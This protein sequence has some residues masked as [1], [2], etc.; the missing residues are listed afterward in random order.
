MDDPIGDLLAERA[1]LGVNPAAGIAVS[2]L[3]HGSVA[4]GI[5]YAAMHAAAPQEVSTL[6]IKFAP[7]APSIAKTITPAAPPPVVEKKVTIPEPIAEAPKAV[8]KS[9]PKSVPFSPFGK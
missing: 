4:A 2:M 1:R 6:S 7:I 5:I 9:E 8:A 3:L